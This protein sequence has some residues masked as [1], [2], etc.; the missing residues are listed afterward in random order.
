LFLLDRQ[1]GRSRER[2]ERARGG[3]GECWRQLTVAVAAP[4]KLLV[5]EGGTRII[6]RG[7]GRHLDVGRRQVAAGSL[8]A[9][10]CVSE[11]GFVTSVD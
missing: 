11:G 9:G 3:S 2:E 6:G 10:G 1:E 7:G 4:L 8:S 5:K